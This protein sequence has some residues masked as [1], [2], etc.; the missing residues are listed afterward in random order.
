MNNLANAIMETKTLLKQA[1]HEYSKY[2][3]STSVHTRREADDRF[4][5]YKNQVRDYQS[6]LTKLRKLFRLN[7][8]VRSMIRGK[9]IFQIEPHT[10][11]REYDITVRDSVYEKAISIFKAFEEGLNEEAK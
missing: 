3:L 6:K 2:M 9:E 1:Q 4:R 11:E 10:S 5:P 8:I 7:H